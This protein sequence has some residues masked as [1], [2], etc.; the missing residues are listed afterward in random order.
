[1]S[2]LEEF[3]F[4]DDM[5]K[6]PFESDKFTGVVQG[7]CDHAREHENTPPPRTITDHF[8]KNVDGLADRV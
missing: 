8:L 4:P 1:M 2:H 6:I 5:S 3:K 7:I